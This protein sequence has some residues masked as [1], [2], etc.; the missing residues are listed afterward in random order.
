MIDISHLAAKEIKKEEA[1]PNCIARHC[2]YID[3]DGRSLSRRL[4]DSLAKLLPAF[5]MLLKRQV[6]KASRDIAC[7][8]NFLCLPSRFLAPALI[9]LVVKEKRPLGAMLSYIPL[10]TESEPVFPTGHSYQEIKAKIP[11][12]LFPGFQRGHLV[13]PRLSGMESDDPQP[14]ARDQTP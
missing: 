12:W 1:F 6:L 4:R 10:E 9:F 5:G 7:G 8:A 11:H 2:R 14:L 13:V 3:Q